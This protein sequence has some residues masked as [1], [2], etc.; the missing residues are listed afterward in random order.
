MGKARFLATGRRA[1]TGEG[2]LQPGP[3]VVRGWQRCAVSRRLRY[4]GDRAG[5]AIGWLTRWPRQDRWILS[6]LFIRK[7]ANT[8]GLA[9][10]LPVRLPLQPALALLV[11]R[12]QQ[13]S[14]A[15]L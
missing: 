5:A 13:L 7:A 6:P 2:R 10:A 15:K 9:P 14:R 12:D 11:S 8:K 4:S 3:T 1:A